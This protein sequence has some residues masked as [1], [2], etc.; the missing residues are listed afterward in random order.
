MCRCQRVTSETTRSPGVGAQPYPPGVRRLAELDD[1]AAAVPEEPGDAPSSAAGSPP[2][3][4]LP[5][6]SSTVRQRPAPGPGRTRRCSSARPPAARVI[7]TAYGVTSMP[8][9]GS[10][11]SASA[12]VSRPGP[13]PTSSVG[14]AQ[15][16]R[17]A[18]VAGPPVAANRST[19]RG[20]RSVRRRARSRPSR[21]RRATF[22]QPADQGRARPPPR[23]GCRVPPPPRVRR[24][25][26]CPR[27]SA[28]GASRRGARPGGRAAARRCR[29][30]TW[31]RRA[32][33]RGSGSRSPSSQNPPSAAG[34]NTASA[35]SRRRPAVVEQCRGDLGGVHADQHGR[36]AGVGEGVCEALVQP[37]A[38]LRDHLEAGGK[39]AAGP[40]G[41]GEHPAPAGR[42][43]LRRRGCRPAPT[44][45]APR[46][47][48]ACT[49]G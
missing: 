49:A 26:R 19:G 43:R 7:S 1:G 12:T 17:S 31:A 27:R 47:A 11:R 29:G 6:A 14:P 37:V 35:P 38:A 3:P 45:R 25:R 16:S 20:S 41:E 8:R 22:V 2:M 30:A 34:P 48:R 40:S 32:A 10:P 21:T 36:A 5:S 24:R 9:A 15:R 46:P 39:P 33:G 13:E 18:S 4:M 28:S 44:R 42:A 23:S